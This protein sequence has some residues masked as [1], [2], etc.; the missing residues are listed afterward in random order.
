MIS[1]FKKQNNLFYFRQITLIYINNSSIKGVFGLSYFE[2]MQINK[3]LF[4]IH[5]LVMVVYEK[6]TYE[7]KIFVC[8]NL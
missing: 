6:T 3:L 1:E 8:E 4:I 2:L 7:D 5:E